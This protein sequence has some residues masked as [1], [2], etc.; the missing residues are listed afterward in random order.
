M[1]ERIYNV[2]LLA[3]LNNTGKNPEVN[4]TNPVFLVGLL[5][6]LGSVFVLQGGGKRESVGQV[7][8]QVGRVLGSEKIQPGAQV[9]R[10]CFI[11]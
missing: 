8:R 7:D 1:T 5:A 9:T 3:R 2:T 11:A 4:Q 6:I 10:A